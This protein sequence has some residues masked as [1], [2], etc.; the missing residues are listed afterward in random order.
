[1]GRR[2][3]GKS[4]Q[5]HSRGQLGRV[6]VRVPESLEVR[7]VEA[8]GLGAYELWMAVTNVMTSLATGFFVAWLQA[9]GSAPPAPEAGV[10]RVV[11]LLFLLLSAASAGITLVVRRRLRGRTRA[12]VVSG[13]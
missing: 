1:M 11:F 10:L 3:T 5:K 9:D 13:R 12:I 7:L 4:L 8:G 6:V 2:M